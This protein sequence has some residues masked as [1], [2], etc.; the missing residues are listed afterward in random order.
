MT[1][2]QQNH[3]AGAKERRKTLTEIGFN[4]GNIRL[5]L[6][7]EGWSAAAVNE[8]IKAGERK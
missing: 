7:Q 4:D 2:E 1:P 8:A 3:I 5:I 6:M